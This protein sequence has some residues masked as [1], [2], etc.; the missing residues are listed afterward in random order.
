MAFGV[1]YFLNAWVVFTL[2]LMLYFLDLF[3]QD[4]TFK[5]RFLLKIA[6][7]SFCAIFCFPLQELNL[8]QCI[9]FSTFLLFCL[10]VKPTHIFS[11]FFDNKIL[12]LHLL[13]ISITPIALRFFFGFFFNPSEYLLIQTYLVFGSFSL[14]ALFV[15][16]GILISLLRVRNFFSLQDWLTIVWIISAYAI[17]L[18]RENTTLFDRTI[19]NMI[20][21]PPYIEG[22]GAFGLVA[23][24]AAFIHLCIVIALV[25]KLR[26]ILKTSK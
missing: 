15:V 5:T 26:Q 6:L 18:W 17:L 20:I 25:A 7:L 14:I 3:K 10:V 2:I 12:Y 1:F 11:S 23:S 9:C 13:F 24:I 16:F 21:N 22:L 19:I 8:T 4:N